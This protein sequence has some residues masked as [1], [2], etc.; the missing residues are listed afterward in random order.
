M[1]TLAARLC[2]VICVSAIRAV[3]NPTLGN[4][5]DTSLPLST[6]TI[7][8]SDAA[9]LL[10]A[11]SV[12]VSTSTDFNG[13]LEG[14]PTSGV[15]RVTNAHPEGTY[16]VTVKAFDR[17]GATAT[18][19]FALTVTT[20]V[21]C[22]PFGFAVATNFSASF[23]PESVAVGDFNG[24]GKQDLAVANLF[25]DASILLGDGTGNFSAPTNFTAGDAP[26]SVVVGDFNGDGKQDLAVANYQ[27]ENV[28]IL[29][30]DGAGNFS[31]PT[32]FTV[33]NGS[34]R[35][36]AVGDFNGDGKQ[37]LAVVTQFSNNIV[38]LLGDGAGNF[39]APTY[40]GNG[41]YPSSVVVGD[42]NND[43][44]QDLAALT[45]SNVS[46]LYG[47]GTGNFSASIDF[48]AGDFPVSVAVGD[49]NGD[50]NQDLAVVNSLYPQG[51]V[52]IL[53]GDGAGNFSAPTSFATAV[54]PARVAVGDF[55]AD[56]RQ[57]LAVANGSFPY[58]MSILLGDGAGNFSPLTNFA[59]GND[60]ESVVVGDFNGDGKQD[61]ATANYFSAGVSVL[62]RNCAA[63]QLTPTGTTCSQFSSGTAQPLGD[64]QFRVDSRLIRRVSPRNFLY[65]LIVTAPAGNNSFTVT[66]TITSNNF[67]T[68]FA[69]VENRSKV[70]DF[71]CG[72]VQRAITQ[73]GNTVTVTF[74]APTA[75]TYFIAI[76]F[77]AHSLIGE[78]EPRPGR[79]V[80]YD[81]TTT[82]VPDSTSGLDLVYTNQLTA[83]SDKH[84]EEIAK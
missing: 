59:V 20:P 1:T 33:G 24:D 5:P 81:F 27:S 79:T 18:K 40:F 58:V 56:G 36:V 25:G 22:N 47:D 74:D 49:F 61:L 28:S 57:D 76:S 82:G 67:G 53:L 7:V 23:Y 45:E 6:D 69:A 26:I 14:N 39:S 77:S 17:S 13:K 65:W 70:F 66:Q 4:Y 31:A 32:N 83:D 43:G 68:F 52:S 54:F 73:S 16:T 10:N 80:H 19:T 75:G 11:T 51:S 78:Q 71:D 9:A 38:V 41:A 12:N 3:A 64:A 8:I 37:D 30:G 2:L 84:Y 21:T 55:N 35:S 72:S 60:P 62:L 29:L 46:I 48:N 15:I 63:S 50:G 42:F 34:P 44:N